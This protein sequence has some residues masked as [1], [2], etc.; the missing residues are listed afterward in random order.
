MVCGRVC[1][2]PSHIILHILNNYMHVCACIHDGDSPYTHT[3]VHY[4]LASDPYTLACM[5]GFL[6]LSYYIC[7]SLK[8]RLRNRNKY[9]HFNTMYIFLVCSWKDMVQ[10][11]AL[12]KRERERNGQDCI[13]QVN[14]KNVLG[15]YI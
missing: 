13:I 3:N 5:S 1:S 4:S 9:S 15:W 7:T 12:L 10:E 14:K 6:L 8:T 2:L 11:K